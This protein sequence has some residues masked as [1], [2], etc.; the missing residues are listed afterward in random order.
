MLGGLILAAWGG[1]RKK[2]HT[3]LFGIVGMGLGILVI[4]L[5]P[6]EGFYVMLGLALPIGIFNSIAN[7]PFSALIQSTVEP[8]MQGRVFS[9]MSSMA[10]GMSPLALIITGPLADLFGVRFFYLLAGAAFVI[11]G[12]GALSVPSLMRLEET[13]P[14][15]VPS[16]SGP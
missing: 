8:R 4:G 2:V 6:P 7:S 5:L 15:E 12:C 13:R 3:I 10:Q 16:A 9:L 1:F 11:V 14:E